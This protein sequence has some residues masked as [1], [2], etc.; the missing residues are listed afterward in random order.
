MF[1]TSTLPNMHTQLHRN[2]LKIHKLPPFWFIGQISSICT[3][4]LKAVRNAWCVVKWNQLISIL[5]WKF[6]V[7]SLMGNT[8]TPEHNW[9]RIGLKEPFWSFL[10]NYCIFS[11][12]S[13]QKPNSSKCEKGKLQLRMFYFL[14]DVSKKVTTAIWRKRLLKIQPLLLYGKG[15][16]MAST[17]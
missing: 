5:F 2:T 15:V 4:V 7:M 11:Y 1:L 9:L 14:R 8:L 10:L 6:H 17:Q 16:L 13:A 12:F 3:N